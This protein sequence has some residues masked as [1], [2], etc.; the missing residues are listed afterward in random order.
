MDSFLIISIRDLFFATIV[1][2]LSFKCI[3][4][5]RIFLRQLDLPSARGRR[6]ADPFTAAMVA[7]R[8]KGR[9]R[10]NV[11]L[12]A[13]I[14]GREGEKFLWMFSSVRSVPECREKLHLPAFY[15]I[16]SLLLSEQERLLTQD[17][18]T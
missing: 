11:R 2:Y 4:S 16:R 18:L 13:S 8:R 1:V 12:V 6:N 15:V 9:A 14:F 10:I 17:M 5:L 3:F 7:A